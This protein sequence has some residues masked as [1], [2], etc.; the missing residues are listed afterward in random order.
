MKKIIIPILLFIGIIQVRALSAAD[1]FVFGDN[2]NNLTYIAEKVGKKLFTIY[3]DGEHGRELWVSDGTVVGTHLVKDIYPGSHD[4]NIE[5]LIEYKGK[6]YFN[7]TDGENGGGLW[8]SD[9]TAA[10][11]HM[12]FYLD[13]Q[14]TSVGPRS[15][16]IFN[17]KL[18]FSFSIYDGESFVNNVYV[19]DGTISGTIKLTVASY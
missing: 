1:A 8:V 17:D 2:E 3:N 13:Q 6:L 9:G 19:T 5:A 15:F 11:T 7:A 16:K 12:A 10:G 14:E 4:S 18:F